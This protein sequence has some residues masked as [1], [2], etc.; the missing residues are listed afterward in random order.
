[1]HRY[2]ILAPTIGARINYN[3]TKETDFHSVHDERY[4][5]IFTF[6]VG[7]GD[8]PIFI[9]IWNLKYRVLLGA[10]LHKTKVVNGSSNEE[11]TLSPSEL[12]HVNAPLFKILSILPR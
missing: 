6:I 7:L 9:A 8:D 4:P 12:S 1:M 3:H 2:N 5:L 10:K 11:V